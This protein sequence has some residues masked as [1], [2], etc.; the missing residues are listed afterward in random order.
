MK[1]AVQSGLLF[2]IVCLLACDSASETAPPAPV[3]KAPEVAAPAAPAPTPAPP[4]PAPAAEPTPAPAAVPAEPDDP[5]PRINAIRARYREIEASAALKSPTTYDAGCN[6]ETRLSAKLY[7][8]DGLQK[9]EVRIHPPGDASDVVYT[10]YFSEQKPVFVLYSVLSFAGGRTSL[11]EQ[12]FYFEN[13]KPLRCLDK[14]AESIEGEDL[15]E[16]E[17]AQRVAS[18]QNKEGSCKDATRALSIARKISSV[19]SNG[20]LSRL[21]R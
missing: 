17:I 3:P 19:D 4:A 15:S 1:V 20:A 11:R 6:D 7:A 14:R 10:V 9:A 13:E 2:S 16:L 21:C 12:R 5:D 8:Q 18:A